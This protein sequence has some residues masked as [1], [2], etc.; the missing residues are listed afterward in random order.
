VCGSH[1]NRLGYDAFLKGPFDG[2]EAIAGEVD[3]IR[4]SLIGVGLYLWKKEPPAG[5][6]NG[7]HPNGSASATHGDNG[8][9]GLHAVGG[10]G[11][12]PESLYCEECGELLTETRFKDNT[13]WVPAQLAVF[14]RRKHSRILCMTHYREAN[15]AKRR[16]NR[17]RFDESSRG[18]GRVDPVDLFVNG[19][20]FAH[21]H[22]L[23]WS[24]QT[25][26]RD[27][28]PASN[29]EAAEAKEA[30]LAFGQGLAYVTLKGR[31]GG[32]ALAA[33]AARTRARPRR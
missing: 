18:S 25:G 26:S 13:T 7:G 23:R 22:L 29:A 12:D 10:A 20:H 16:A 8:T 17:K 27:V 3:N 33:A 5:L 30:L 24:G 14:G 2:R 4:S 9:G 21:G 6:G 11:V 32:S 1:P 28:A 15:Q 31:R 19:L